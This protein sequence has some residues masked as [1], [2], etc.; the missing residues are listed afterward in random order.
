MHLHDIYLPRSNPDPDPDPLPLNNWALDPS[1]VANK[2]SALVTILHGTATISL[3]E[4]ILG[5]HLHNTIIKIKC[6]VRETV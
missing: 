5:A 2:S 1:R 4:E 3:L 6:G